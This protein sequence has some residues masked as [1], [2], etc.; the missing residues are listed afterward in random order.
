MC[1][2]VKLRFVLLGKNLGPNQMEIPKKSGGKTKKIKS[3]VLKGVKSN[4][5]L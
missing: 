3:L 5:L 2:V 4:K 1:W